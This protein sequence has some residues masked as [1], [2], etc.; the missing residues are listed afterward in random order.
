MNV[1]QRKKATRQ[2][3]TGEV[4]DE[5]RDKVYQVH[6]LLALHRAPLELLFRRRRRRRHLVLRHTRQHWSAP[7]RNLGA[8][9]PP[10]VSFPGRHVVCGWRVHDILLRRQLG[11]GRGGGTDGRVESFLGSPHLGQRAECGI[12]CIPAR[13]KK[14]KKDRGSRLVVLQ[15][16]QFH[17]AFH[18]QRQEELT[19]R[20]KAI[21]Y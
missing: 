7:N 20:R 8:D 19:C 3:G 11:R 16:C 5:N 14:K 1:P 10:G 2:D 17:S 18:N 12:V 9:A 6:P 21:W 15:N 13:S 4:R